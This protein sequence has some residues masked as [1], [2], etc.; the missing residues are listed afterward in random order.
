MAS[1]LA[2]KSTSLYI[3]NDENLVLLSKRVLL[4][5]GLSQED[6]KLLFI[7]IGSHNGKRIDVCT[8]ILGHQH[9]GKKPLMLFVHGYAAAGALYY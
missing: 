8:T 1:N 9:L 6:I 4:F 3:L 5:S 7:K 2:K